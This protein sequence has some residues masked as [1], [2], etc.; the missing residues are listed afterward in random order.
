VSLPLRDG[1]RAVVLDDQDRVL[2]VRFHFS[3]G[4]L[5]AT[6]G[7]GVEP[8][9]SLETA[10]RRELLEEVGLADVDLGPV[11]W[12]RTH[13]FPLSEVFGGQ[14]EKFFLARTTS[15]VIDPLFSEQELLDEGLTGSRW[16]TLPEIRD[17]RDVRFAPSRLAW[18]LE[19]LL[20]HG[21]PRGI[22][23]TGV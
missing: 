3:S 16:W 11:I 1:V 7:G 22:I 17:S 20:E 10:I 13:V 4:E 9:E 15:S 5:W 23:D 19:A 12:E 14:R 18:F 6:P 8:G 21:P 2:L